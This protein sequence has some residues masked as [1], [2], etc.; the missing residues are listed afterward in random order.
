MR[1]ILVI[2]LVVVTSAC[3]SGTWS[4]SQESNSSVYSG[5]PSV[6]AYQWICQSLHRGQDFAPGS[7]IPAGRKVKSSSAAKKN[8]FLALQDNVFF[9]DFNGAF[10]EKTAQALPETWR[11][12]PDS[13][14]PEFTR[15]EKAN[16]KSTAF[17]KIYIHT[18]LMD[19]AYSGRFY[20]FVS[21]SDRSTQET[22]T[23]KAE[24]WWP[25]SPSGW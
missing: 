10:A 23:C 11:R 7:E 1:W 4:K 24:R 20:G 25:L 3:V 17:Q 6:V 21:G 13:G 16:S 2:G 19:G 12:T 22:F 8:V 14:M 15:F 5:L 18:D 9:F